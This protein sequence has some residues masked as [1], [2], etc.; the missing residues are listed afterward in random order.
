[1]KRLIFQVLLGTAAVLACATLAMKGGEK[2]SARKHSKFK[3]IHVTP[4]GIA[5]TAENLALVSHLSVLGATIPLWNYSVVAYD[6]ATYSGTIVGRNPFFHG[7][8]T[9]TIPTYLV[10]VK[11]T[12]ADTNEVFDPTAADPCIS[13]STVDSLV[14]ASPIFKTSDFVMNGVDV[15]TAQYLDAFERAS[16]WS[17]V[18]GTPYHTVFTAT[19]TV[20]PAVSVTVPT[21]NGS[22]FN[23]SIFGGC[24]DMGKMDIAWW[25]NYLQTTILPSLA[26]QGVGPTN[27]PQ[28]VFD[29]VAMTISDQ[30]CALGYHN[31]FINGSGNLQ[32][33]SA[34]DFD[35]SLAFGGIDIGAMSHE[36]AE[37]MDDPVGTNP[38]PAWGAEGQVPSGSC[39]SNL[40]VGDPLSSPPTNPF[41]VLLSGHTYTLQELAF[42]SW[43]YGLV[44][45]QGAGGKYSDNGTFTGTAIACPPGGSN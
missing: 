28:F 35:T 15:G 36:V 26:G 13:N 19:P 25:E 7:H 18:G 11:F 37:W 42:Y 34:N 27:F 1:M 17:E 32:T 39:Q 23:K 44:P 22:T 20:L 12:F 3:V 4:H 21:L 45:S 8:R 14:L 30:C 33:Y 29:S 9:T 40:E 16:F 5:P 43:F 24:R 38:T 41:S 6:G 2:A 10:P 31:A